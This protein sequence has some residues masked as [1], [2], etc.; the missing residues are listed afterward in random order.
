MLKKFEV[1]WAIQM[2]IFAIKDYEGFLHIMLETFDKHSRM[3]TV[4]YHKR[5]LTIS[6]KAIEFTRVFGVLGRYGKKIE[7]K[8]KKMKKGRK[9]V[10]DKFYISRTHTKRNG[11]SSGCNQRT[12]DRKNFCGRGALAMSI[13]LGQK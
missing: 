12:W 13:G 8:A 7:I 1:H 4:W 11:F 5:N 9:R 3:T 2:P 6:F 10:L